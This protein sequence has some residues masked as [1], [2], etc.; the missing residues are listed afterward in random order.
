VGDTVYAVVRLTRGAAVRPAASFAARISY[1]PQRLSFVDEASPSS[2][3]LR[4]VNADIAGD[5]RMAGLATEGFRDGSL[6]VLRFVA[7]ALGR[8][9]ALQLAIDE[10]HTVDGQDLSRTR[11]LAPSIDAGVAP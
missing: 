8:I 1:D 4:V 6:V 3:A 10:L 11:I 7:T 2:A 9:G 5:V